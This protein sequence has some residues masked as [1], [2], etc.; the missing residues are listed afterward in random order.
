MRYIIKFIKEA[1]EIKALRLNKFNA[2]PNLTYYAVKLYATDIRACGPFKK[3]FL[4]KNGSKN[5]K[6]L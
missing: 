4:D 2:L 5:S 6:F 3:A 1:I